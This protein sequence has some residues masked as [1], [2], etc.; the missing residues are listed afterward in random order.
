MFSNP[1]IEV[2]IIELLRIWGELVEA[3][4][5]VNS[6][7]GHTAEIYSYRLQR[8]SPMAHIHDDKERQGEIN[9]KAANALVALLEEFCR[10]YECKVMVDDLQLNDWC[11]QVNY[12]QIIFDHRVHITVI[13]LI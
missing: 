7:G 11:K 12:R 13:H 2:S 5:G 10:E 4:H 6:F 9:Q 3:Y 8:F 1:L